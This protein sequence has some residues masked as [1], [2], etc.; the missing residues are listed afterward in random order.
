MCL[1]DLFPGVKRL[2]QNDKERQLVRPP[3]PVFQPI[4]KGGG[5]RGKKT[6]YK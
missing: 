4:G 1:I 6:K 2:L 5:I 3:I